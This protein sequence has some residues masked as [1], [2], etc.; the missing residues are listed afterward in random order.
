M[1]AELPAGRQRKAAAGARNTSSR[2]SLTM[3]RFTV[4]PGSSARSAFSASIT[5]V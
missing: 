4:M 2:R 5:A 3:R 1:P